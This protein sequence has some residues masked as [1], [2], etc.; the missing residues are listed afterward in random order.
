MKTNELRQQ[1]KPT[2]KSMLRDLE[3]KKF[4]LK[5]QHG[6][7]QLQGTHQLQQVRRDIARVKTI[8]TEL[9]NNGE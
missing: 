4:K 9:E 7:G 5:M 3:K 1:D 2:L 8:M 6:S